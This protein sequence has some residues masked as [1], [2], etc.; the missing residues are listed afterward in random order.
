VRDEGLA[1][2][3]LIFIS[4]VVALREELAW[5]ERRPLFGKRVLVTR[6]RHQ[7]GD[8]VHRL[9]DLGAVVFN[10]PTV[11]IREP[12]DWAPVDQAI[13]S[14]GQY[15]W[16]VFTSANGICSFLGRVKK[17]GLDMRALGNVRIAAI[18]PKTADALRG[19]HLLP[20]LVPPHFQSED[21]AAALLTKIQAGQRVLLARADR[22]RDV[23]RQQLAPTCLVE[24]IAV[25][26]QVDAVESDDEVMNALRRGEIEF[27]T[28]TSSN[29]ARSLLDR[30]DATCRRR[31]QSG[32]IKLVSI[33]PVTSA[34]VQRLGYH[35]AAEATQATTDGVIEAL[36][37]L[38]CKAGEKVSAVP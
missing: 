38:T 21:L 26:S 20:D 28:L 15:D 11:E 7:A 29:I 27:V 4:P 12:A 35:V 30:L 37:K 17:L 10:L 31:I 36:I 5:F 19:Y 33:S 14:L 1:A 2:P 32:E 18:G 23:L 16:L 22:G 24:Q 3:A 8:M 6:P 25:Y 34:E 13:H 9:V